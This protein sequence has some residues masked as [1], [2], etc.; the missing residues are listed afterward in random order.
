QAAAAAL[1]PG[2]EGWTVDQAARQYIVN[3][4]YEEFP[5]ALGHQV[6]R[7]AHDGAGLLCPV[8]DRYKKLP[9]LKVEAGQVY[10]LEPR[11]TVPGHGVVTIE[12]MVVVSG[13]G[14]EF[15]STPQTALWVV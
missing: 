3:A 4:G 13:S 2:V 8:W 14:C 10:T 5:H 12:E 7:S 9:F 11:L 6:G 15:L 1:K